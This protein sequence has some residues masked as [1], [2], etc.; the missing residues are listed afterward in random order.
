M[1]GDKS[2]A[3]F[4][5]LLP[6]VA[7]VLK[8]LQRD[9]PPIDDLLHPA[10]LRQV[11]RDSGLFLESRLRRQPP[12]EQGKT[13]ASSAAQPRP[14][15]EQENLEPDLK[16]QLL[17]LSG[18]T[19]ER[20]QQLSAQLPFAEKEALLGLQRSLD[21][22][23]ATIS[24]KQLSSARTEAQVGTGWAFDIP[25]RWGNEATVLSLYIEEQGERD[26]QGE[27]GGN[28]RNWRITLHI[29]VPALGPV[30]A[31]LAL[32]YPS[33]QIRFYAQQQATARL[34]GQQ[35]EAL[36]ERLQQGGLQVVLLR[37]DQGIRQR[38]GALVEGYREFHGKVDESA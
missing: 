8:Q 2:G 9:L 38:P 30:E 35:A 27:D 15:L 23:L 14:N 24:L 5:S 1:A 4:L 33:L 36:C 34:L 26:A 7:S 6:G 31:E 28:H 19:R 12:P 17:Q 22:A 29:D 37:S 13:D 16:A 20:I 3:I 18:Q 21:G 10:T 11:A 32:Q 25:L